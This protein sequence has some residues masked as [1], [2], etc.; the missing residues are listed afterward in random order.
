MGRIRLL[1]FLA[2]LFSIWVIY[3]CVSHVNVSDIKNNLSKYQDRQ[4]VVKGVVMD[5][6]GLPFAHKGIFKIDDGTDTIWV[7]STK[8]PIKG[9]RVVVK[10]IVESALIVNDHTFGTM[11]VEKEK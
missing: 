6:I 7:S 1:Y 5:T 10:G 9:E 8:V 4:V 2:L 11:I 3:G